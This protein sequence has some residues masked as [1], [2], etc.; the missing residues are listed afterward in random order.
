MVNQSFLKTWLQN[1][2]YQS[3]VEFYLVHGSN[4]SLKRLFQQG[5]SAFCIKKLQ[6]EIS[7]LANLPEQQSKQIKE[8]AFIPVP[9]W[10]TKKA[11]LR[12]KWIKEQQ[13]LRSQLIHIKT[14]DE[15][16]LSAFKILD[17]G[18]LIQIAQIEMEEFKVTGKVPIT[19]IPKKEPFNYSN[20]CD[21]S[22]MEYFYNSFKP[23][24]SR[25]KNNPERYA[26]LIKEEPVLMAEIERRRKK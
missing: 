16:R 18:D 1:P 13:W 14:D 21:I 3:G 24:K 5:P 10:F 4:Q 23:M 2:N 8:Q 25:N 20:L 15:R 7:I 17:L 22:L 9:D 12:I 11:E 6:Q 19:E 26:E